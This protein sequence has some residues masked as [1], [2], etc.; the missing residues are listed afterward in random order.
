MNMKGSCIKNIN[1]TNVY[2]AIFDEHDAFTV[3]ETCIVI[4]LFL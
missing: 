1:S 2:E 3:E 4:K